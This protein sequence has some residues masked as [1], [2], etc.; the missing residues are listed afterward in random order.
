MA[1]FY[2]TVSGK[3]RS[4]A[5]RLGSKSSGLRT[6]AAS[7]QGAV[8]VDLYERDGLDCAQI[9]LIPWHGHGTTR[10]IYD[11]P[12]SGAPIKVAAGECAA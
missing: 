8:A 5:S 2:G 3:A 1:H 4:Q 11:G 12:V 7:W 6:V 10:V 9:T